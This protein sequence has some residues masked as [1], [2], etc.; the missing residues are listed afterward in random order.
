MTEGK[1][2]LTLQCDLWKR[3]VDEAVEL[4]DR[5]EDEIAVL[6]IANENLIAQL[7]EVRG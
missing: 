7:E 2:W 4:V 6:K 5:L 1:R 3:R